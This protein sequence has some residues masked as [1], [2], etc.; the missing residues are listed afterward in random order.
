LL[1]PGAATWGS[2]EPVRRAGTALSVAA[3]ALGLTAPGA[4]ATSDRAE[5]LAQVNPICATANQ[6]IDRLTGE[7]M[8]KLK[9]AEKKQK[10]QGGGSVVVFPSAEGKKQKLPPFDKISQL[11]NWYTRQVL[12][13][14]DSELAS[15]RAVAPAPGDE[16]LVA[17][18]LNARGL[19]I[20]LYRQILPIEKQIE[21]LFFASPR[22]PGKYERIERRLKKLERRSNQIYAQLLA[23]YENDIELGAQLGASYC[24]TQA[25]GPTG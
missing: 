17:D 1:L 3:V 19:Q 25:S 16:T 12:A 23:A 24:V 14:E 11:F 6:E 4:A 5:Y 18:W 21:K 8:R 2:F 15:L 13:V 10:D 20:A 9:R 7:V 22:S